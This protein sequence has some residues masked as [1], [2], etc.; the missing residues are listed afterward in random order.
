MGNANCS[1]VNDT[2]ADVHLRV[3]NFA[4]G[5]REMS[6]QR[7]S[8]KPRQWVNPEAAAHG[9]GLILAILPGGDA[10]YHMACGNGSTVKA[11]Q[12]LAAHNRT[13]RWSQGGG[14]LARG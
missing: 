10:Q 2:G 14:M 9:S 11:S 3:Y 7:F 8:V 6:R 4:D 12:V 13:V 5:L 1:F